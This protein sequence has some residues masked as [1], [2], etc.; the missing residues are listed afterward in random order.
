MHF[1]AISFVK[2]CVD[3]GVLSSNT[4]PPTRYADMRGGQSSRIVA[5]STP[6]IRKGWL[7]HLRSSIMMFISDGRFL[8]SLPTLRLI[9]STDPYNTLVL[10]SYTAR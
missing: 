5:A 7:Q 8:L 3:C 1:N 6:R 2:S 9:L 10:W 4:D